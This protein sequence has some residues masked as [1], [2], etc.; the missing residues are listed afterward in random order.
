MKAHHRIYSAKKALT[1]WRNGEA[2]TV[3]IVPCFN[4]HETSYDIAKPGVV[5]RDQ[6]PTMTGNLYKWT[7]LVQL[8]IKSYTLD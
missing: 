3:K 4:K 2:S 1:Q 5:M 7:T 6:L 8:L